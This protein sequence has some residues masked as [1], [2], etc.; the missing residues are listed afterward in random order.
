MQFINITRPIVLNLTVERA[1]I[2]K[3]RL[4]LDV[5]AIPGDMQY[6]ID[7]IADPYLFSK[8]LWE[9]TDQTGLTFDVFSG[10]LKPDNLE[11]LAEAFTREVI[12]FFPLAIRDVMIQFLNGNERSNRNEP[13]DESRNSPTIAGEIYGKSPDSSESIQDHS[14][15]GNWQTCVVADSGPS[16][17]ELRI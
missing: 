11:E 17:N 8:I 4:L 6:L 16:G 12:S 13:S 2:L 15:F 5:M 14:P 9:C 7:A 3:E 10:F 1:I